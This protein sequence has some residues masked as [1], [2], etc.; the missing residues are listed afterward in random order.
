MIRRFCKMMITKQPDKAAVWGRYQVA[1]NAVTVVAQ[2]QWQVVK[3][4]LSIQATIYG[5]ALV[6]ER[7]MTSSNGAFDD[8]RNVVE[9]KVPDEV[10][11]FLK[12]RRLWTQHTIHCEVQFYL[13]YDVLHLVRILSTA[14]DL[15]SHQK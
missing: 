8:Y 2:Q 4:E 3:L 13:S 5:R 1:K 7:H 14:A 15:Q 12:D 11:R 10:F 6:F 9:H